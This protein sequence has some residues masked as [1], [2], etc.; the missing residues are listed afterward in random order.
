MT[1]ILDALTLE[2]IEDEEQYGRERLWGAVS[3][4]VCSVIIGALMDWLI[5]YTLVLSIVIMLIG[6]LSFLI[7]LEQTTWE[8]R[9]RQVEEHS[10]SPKNSTTPV[11]RQWIHSGKMIMLLSTAVVLGAATSLVDNLLFLHLRIELKAPNVACGLSVVVTVL[12]E[13]PLF[14][15]SKKLLRLLSPT[16]LILIGMVSYSLR[17]FVYTVVE[18]VWELLSVE[19]LHGVTYSLTHLAFVSYIHS[20]CPPEQISEGQGLRTVAQSTGTLLGTFIGGIVMEKLGS[21]VLYLSASIVVLVNCVA[22]AVFFSCK[23]QS[24]NVTMDENEQSLEV[25]MLPS[26]RSVVSD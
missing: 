13:I 16:S 21:N 23:K 24:A 7:M 10:T 20:N 25:E 26:E 1:A 6:T 14:S 19:P 8:V 3:W 18:N 4:A 12:F 22:V 11:W 17:V 5:G 15:S 2:K 9:N